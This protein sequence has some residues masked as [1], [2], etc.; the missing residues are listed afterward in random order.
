MGDPVRICP[1][2]SYLANLIWCS[3]HTMQRQVPFIGFTQLMQAFSMV[4]KRGAR[5]YR[6]F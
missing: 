3:S 5:L 6:Y 2:H 4:S 1:Q